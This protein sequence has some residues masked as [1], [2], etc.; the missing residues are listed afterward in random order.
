MTFT[1]NLLVSFISCSVMALSAPTMAGNMQ[2]EDSA[3][4]KLEFDGG[5][6]TQSTMTKLLNEMDR[7]RATEA[8]LWGIPAA[9]MIEWKNAQNNVFKIRD[10][11]LVSYITQKQK[12]GILTPNFTTPYIATFADLSK[13]GPLVLTLPKGLMAGMVMDVHQRVLQDLGVA[14]PDKGQGG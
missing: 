12:Q 5:Y 9:G 11:Q 1:R 14:G 8:Y 6:P 2:T 4:G 7:V 13:T 10:G 3:I